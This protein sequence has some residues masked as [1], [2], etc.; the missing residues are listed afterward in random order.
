MKL[1]CI[2]HFPIDLEQQI[3]DRL[4]F[5]I[6]KKMVNTILFQVGL[7]RLRKYFSVRSIIYKYYQT[8]LIRKNEFVQANLRQFLRTNRIRTVSE[9]SIILSSTISAKYI[10][11]WHARALYGVSGRAG[12]QIWFFHGV[13]Y[14]GSQYFLLSKTNS[15]C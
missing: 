6:N 4:L 2:Y 7:I 1:N 9:K 11:I 13:L 15:K 12:M 10:D 3:S 14:H 5:K 8:N